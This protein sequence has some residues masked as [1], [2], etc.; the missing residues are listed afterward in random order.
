MGG[1][2]LEGVEVYITRRQNMVAQYIATRQILELGVEVKRRTGSWVSKR[3][4]E[5]RGFNF[6]GAQ[7]AVAG[8]TEDTEE[9]EGGED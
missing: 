8:E 5:Q 9:V 7:T 2:G 1:A 4:W 3:W 6:E